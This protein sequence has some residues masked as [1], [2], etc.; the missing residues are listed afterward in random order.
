M[1]DVPD[2]SC[3]QWSWYHYPCRCGSLMWYLHPNC[4]DLAYSTCH[5]LQMSVP[6]ND[7]IY[8][9]TYFSGLRT[10]LNHDT[11]MFRSNKNLILKDLCLQSKIFS[12]CMYVHRHVIWKHSMTKTLIERSL[13]KDVE[14]NLYCFFRNLL[15]IQ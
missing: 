1:V 5:H 13:S 14:M 8:L 12:I 10:C 9:D 7:H 11:L 15:K 6:R 3:T 2:Y 4:A